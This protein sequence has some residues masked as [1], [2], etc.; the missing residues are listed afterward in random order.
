MKNL[1]LSLFAVALSFAI[2]A[3]AQVYTLTQTTLSSAV[4]S[5][6]VQTVLVTSATN[7][8]AGTMLYVENEAMLALLVNG[9]AITVARGLQTTR[10]VGH[11]SLAMVLAGNPDWFSDSDPTGMCVTASTK[12]APHIN[13]ITGKEWLC[14]PITLSWVPGFQNYAQYPRVTAAVASAA[15]TI[16]PSGPLFH[17]TGT[18]AITG[19][20]IPVGFQY[21]SFSIIP[22]GGFTT[23]TAGNIAIASTAV[24]NKLLT[25]TW[26]DT[27]SKFVPSY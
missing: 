27:N 7:I 19:F 17:V 4:S 1:F 24:V 16:T 9:T 10:A 3:D 13:V 12:T 22:D 6:A 21:G 20:V 18:A 25:F 15:G 8:T 14:S 5:G 11:P 26:D 23:T 2:A